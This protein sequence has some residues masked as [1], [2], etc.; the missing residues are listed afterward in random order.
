MFD[1]GFWFTPLCLLDHFTGFFH[2]KVIFDTARFDPSIII[3]PGEYV[4]FTLETVSTSEKHILK[5]LMKTCNQAYHYNISLELC[6]RSVNTAI[7]SCLLRPLIPPGKL[8]KFQLTKYISL[9]N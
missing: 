3:Y 5:M 1:F 8:Y 4:M 7:H 6:V 9:P 2:L